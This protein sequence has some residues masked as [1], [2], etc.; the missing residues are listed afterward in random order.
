MIKT[1]LPDSDTIRI[2]STGKK[3]GAD[4]FIKEF[5]LFFD[6]KYNEIPPYHDRWNQYCI[7]SVFMYNRE[8]SNKYYFISYNKF[9]KL[10]DN[11]IIFEYSEQQD[12][13]VNTIIELCIKHNKKYVIIKQ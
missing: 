9:I 12:P 8:F 3:Y 1:E 13:S 11:I 7:D 5:A 2:L 4:K 10:S 6:L